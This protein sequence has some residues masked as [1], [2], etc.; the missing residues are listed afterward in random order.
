MKAN[1]NNAA[2]LRLT[3]DSE[4]STRIVFDKIGFASVGSRSDCCVGAI[5]T[6][7]EE[8]LLRKRVR[9]PD[10]EL[11]DRDGFRRRGRGRGDRDQD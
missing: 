9:R 4:I 11:R 10:R 2:S 5:A 1:Y 3:G 6:R 8:F 7:K